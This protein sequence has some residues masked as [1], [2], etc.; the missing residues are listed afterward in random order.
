[1]ESHDKKKILIVDDSADTI[2]IIG[3]ILERSFFEISIAKSGK[4]CLEILKKIKPEMILLDIMMPDINGIEVCKIIR[5]KYDAREMP[6]I[7]ISASLDDQYLAEAFQAGGNDFIH[8]PINKT[9]LQ[10]RVRSTLEQKE[11]AK[12]ILQEEK[13]VGIL[14]MAGAVCHELNQPLQVVLGYAELLIAKYSAD[15]PGYEYVGKIIENS[16]KISRITKKLSKITKYETKKYIG[17]SKI[18]DIEKSID[19][20]S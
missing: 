17:Q 2:Y 8:K 15:T 11:L 20:R 10:T 5:Q 7:F 14:E 18:I 16:M 1:M 12:R 3:H 13:L 9:E 4:E 19:N 6:I